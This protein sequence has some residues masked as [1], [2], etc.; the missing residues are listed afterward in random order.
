MKSNQ[1]IA[2]TKRMLQEGLLRLLEEKDIDHINVSELCDE[3]GINRATFYRHY[4][5]PKDVLTEL[6]RNMV[7]DMQLLNVPDP[8][9]KDAMKDLVHLCN[10]CHDHSKHLK[11]LFDCHLEEGFTEMLKE[12]LHEHADEFKQARQ[13]YHVDEEEL[14]LASHF[15]AGGIYYIIRRWIT[16]YSDKTPEQVAKLI[17]RII[18]ADTD[19]YESNTL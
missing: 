5:M 9:K 4:Q 13:A 19:S 10:Y 8:H 1:R 6:L 7:D 12:F 18:S 16:E 2:V 3:S 14:I 17:Y 11:I 15:Y